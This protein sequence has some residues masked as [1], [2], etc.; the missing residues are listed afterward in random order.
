MDSVAEQEKRIDQHISKGKQDAA[1]KALF[2]LIVECA[3]K[4]DFIKAE[5]LR[6]KLFD[7]AP[8][9]LNEITRAADIIDEEKSRAIDENHRKAFSELYS[10]LTPEE[11]NE[12]YFSMKANLYKEGEIIFS[13]GDEDDNL[14]FLDIG[15]VKMVHRKDDKEIL[16]NLEP[17]DIAGEDTFFYSTA[18]KTVS[19]I[20]NSDVKLLSVGREVQERWNERFP[21]L[22]QKLY[23]YCKSAGTVPD[24]LKNKGLSRRKNKRK[25]PTGKVAV[26]LLSSS[27]APTGKQF[28]GAL[29]DISVS[30]LS[31]T[32]KLSNNEVAHELLGRKIKTQLVIPDGSSSKKIEQIGKIVGIG[33]HVLSD[34]SIHVRFDKNDEAIRKLIGG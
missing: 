20:A 6:E 27:G 15:K 17:G 11:A 1:V 9:A 8:L 30:G 14:Y 28:M 23:E 10:K 13:T 34:H 18:L 4:K 31:F 7:V 3:R 16:K 12:L 32:F 25:K 24:L 22:Q 33:Y 21:G 2:D 29:C 26:H 19:L 5:D